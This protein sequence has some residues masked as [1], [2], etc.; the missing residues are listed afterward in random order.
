M[1][2]EQSNF[3]L[4]GLLLLFGLFAGQGANKLGLPRV[5]AYV[6]TGALFSPELLGHYFQVNAEDSS[7]PLI[8]VALSLIAF[9]I[10]GSI[11]TAQLQRMGKSML[12]IALGE[13]LGAIGMVFLGL[14]LLAPQLDGIS[15]VSVALAFAAIAVTTEP[16]GTIAVIHQ[17]RA[18]GVLS[19]TLLGVVALD[20]AL[21]II[22][23]SVV[24]AFLSGGSIEQNIELAFFEIGVAVL[25]GIISGLILAKIAAYI[26][27]KGLLL[28]LTL[29][30]I[31]MVLGL[32]E[33]FHF[34]AL[35]SSMALGFSSRL[36]LNSAGDKLFGSI[37]FL[38]ETVFLLFFTLAGTHFHS[39]IFLQHFDIILI[40]FFARIVGKITGSAFGAKITNTPHL[41]TR[42]LGFALIPQAGV[43]VGLALTLSHQSEFTEI[44]SIILNVILANT[45]ITE[46]IGPITARFALQK[47]GEISV[48][49]V[50]RKGN[51]V[52]R[53]QVHRLKYYSKYRGD[54]VL[55]R[56]YKQIDQL[57][58]DQLAIH[59]SKGHS[60]S[61][62]GKVFSYSE[63]KC[64]V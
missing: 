8:N 56:N 37:D 44:S 31:L 50:P 22:F 23:F 7:Q 14:I 10:G 60:F 15:P 36:F 53:K 41:V 57:E 9:I 55:K 47:A 46:L 13:S 34:S 62:I 29:G 32:A 27:Q 17:Y 30:F 3:L 61:A 5:A 1:D 63:S 35:L 42:W 16:A 45:L 4:L 19:T 18:K 40:Y 43:A 20:D 11:T 6:L 12:G 54:D 59:R 28:P 58:R 48:E 24:I 51:L 52:F 25:L 2:V 21:G 33:M 64:I 49:K 39:S 26:Q 38:E